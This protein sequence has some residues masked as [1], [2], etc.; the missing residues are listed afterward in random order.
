MGARSEGVPPLERC[1]ALVERSDGIIFGSSAAA[2]PQGTSA[3]GFRQ[4]VQLGDDIA[5]KHVPKGSIVKL[6]AEK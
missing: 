5:P 3:H 4:V 6:F 2:R 1:V